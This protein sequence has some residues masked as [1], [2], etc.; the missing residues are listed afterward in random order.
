MFYFLIFLY[1]KK[2]PTHNIKRTKKLVFTLVLLPNTLELP[3][4]HE[5]HF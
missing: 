1:K 3:Q 4:E 2:K 5:N